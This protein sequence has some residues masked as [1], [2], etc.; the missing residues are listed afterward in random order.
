MALLGG[1]LQT[2]CRPSKSDN[3]TRPRYMRSETDSDYIR[4]AENVKRM[5]DYIKNVKKKDPLCGSFFSKVSGHYLLLNF[6][7]MAYKIALKLSIAPILACDDKVHE[8]THILFTYGYL[9]KVIGLH[10]IHG[11]R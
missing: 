4:Q 7:Y 6:T 9:N 2:G 11:Q 5:A 3:D 1:E 8:Q 10:H